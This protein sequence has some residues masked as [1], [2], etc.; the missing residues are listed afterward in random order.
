MVEVADYPFC[1]A[2]KGGSGEEARPV[3]FPRNLG[4]TAYNGRSPAVFPVGVVE[5]R[6]A[7]PDSPRIPSPPVINFWGFNEGGLKGKGGLGGEGNGGNDRGARAT[8]KRG[9]RAKR[10]KANGE[11]RR[12][13]PP[14]QEER[15]RPP[16]PESP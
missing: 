7:S 12:S 14:R 1:R 3:F 8:K 5:T 2:G 16:R 15:S 10:T 13:F 9:K 11:P 6:R 4:K